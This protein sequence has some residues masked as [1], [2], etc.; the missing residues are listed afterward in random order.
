[1]HNGLFKITLAVFIVSILLSGCGDS[2]SDDDKTSDSQSDGKDNAG[3]DSGPGSDTDSDIDT[4]SDTDSD[5]DTDA[6]A[7]GD[8]GGVYADVTNVSF[9]G[10]ENAWYFS[11]TIESAD[12]DCTQYCDWWEILTPSGELV[13]RRIL[14][15][16]HTDE[17]G[18]GN[19]FTREATEPAPVGSDDVLIFRA[20]MNE[21][22]Y[23]GR[24]MRGSVKQGFENAP[25][26]GPDFA[27]NV[28]D[29]EPQPSDCLF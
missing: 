5:T 23:R 22:G 14:G 2:G 10:S 4:D 6:D 26:I 13:L 17:N 12:I 20:H 24:A 15:H 9:R 18:T 3:D 28:E 21:A 1:M 27:K 25:D 8:A 7:D 29:D 19:P 16:S 11:T